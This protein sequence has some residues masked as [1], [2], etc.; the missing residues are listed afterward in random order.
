MAYKQTPG[1]GNGKKTGAGISPMLM[2]GSAMYQTGDVEKTGYGMVKEKENKAKV[3]AD[4]KAQ[5]ERDA[6]MGIKR[7]F[8]TNELTPVITDHKFDIAG[9]FAREIDT[10]GNVVKE[11]KLG[12]GGAQSPQALELKKKVEQ[13]N[14]RLRADRS[15]TAEVL[16]AFGGGTPTEKLS[17][18]Q[19]Q[20]L[21]NSTRARVS[22]AN[23]MSK[24][25]FKKPAMTST[26]T[27]PKA[28]K[29]PM[30]QGTVA[31]SRTPEEEKLYKDRMSKMTAADHERIKS[32]SKRPTNTRPTSTME[33]N[34]GGVEPRP[35]KA[36]TMQMSKL[37]KKS[38]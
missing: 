38:C 25:A 37:K 33:R 23:Q 21:I 30:K 20:T 32:G 4:P 18:K 26:T 1:R 7:N 29:T 31:V 10:K 13:R 34:R 19:K 12:L 15:N 22:P 8:A 11:V 5:A 35:R 9:S 27:K 16:N 14:S 3:N 6:K 36:P 2:S 24:G 17:E 28:S